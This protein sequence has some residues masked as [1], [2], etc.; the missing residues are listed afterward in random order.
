MGRLGSQLKAGSFSSNGSGRDLPIPLRS[1][2]ASGQVNPVEARPPNAQP[3]VGFL[4]RT[5]TEA[6]AG[7]MAR[8]HRELRMCRHPGLGGGPI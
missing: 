6:T 3:E 2:Q 5:L 4:S 1:R 8:I 7:L